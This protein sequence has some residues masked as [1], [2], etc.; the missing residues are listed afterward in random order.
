MQICTLPQTDNH[1]STTPLSFLQTRCPSCHSTKSVKALTANRLLFINRYKILQTCTNTQQLE[2]TTLS[3]RPHNSH[4]ITTHRHMPHTHTHTHTC[5]RAHART[6]AHAHAHT[7][8]KTNIY[9]KYKQT[10]LSGALH[11]K[12]A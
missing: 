11:R 6:H 9:T 5:A 12:V 7:Y 2:N 1:A 4:K 8:R 10:I 3:N